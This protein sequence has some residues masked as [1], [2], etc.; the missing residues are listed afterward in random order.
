MLT[1]RN[2]CCHKRGLKL[3]VHDWMLL[4]WFNQS[5]G[6]RFTFCAQ[7]LLVTFYRN[8]KRLCVY[9]MTEALT[10][11]RPKLLSSLR[12]SKDWDRALFGVLTSR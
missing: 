1:L 12:F 9:V 7:L 10:V 4:Y 8:V 6:V 11:M 2:E 5:K 3:P